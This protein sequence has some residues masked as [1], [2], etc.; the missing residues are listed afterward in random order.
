VKVSHDV[1]EYPQARHGF[2]NDHGAGAADGPALFAVMARLMPGVGY[3]EAAAA[4]ARQR[5]REFFR[6]HLASSTTPT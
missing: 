1:R 6:A 5:I 4:D 2:L 3:D